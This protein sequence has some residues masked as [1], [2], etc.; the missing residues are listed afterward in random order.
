MKWFFVLY[1]LLVNLMAFIEYGRDKYKAVHAQWRISENRLLGYAVFGGG[2]GALLGMIRF[3]HK[4][5]KFRFWIVNS[6]MIIIHVGIWIGLSE[7]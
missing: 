3:H 1:Y 2:M 6:F 5:R 4:T 7:I